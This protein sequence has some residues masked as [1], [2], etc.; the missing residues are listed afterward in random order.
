MFTPAC[1]NLIETQSPVFSIEIKRRLSSRLFPLTYNPFLKGVD[2]LPCEACFY[3][4]GGYWLCD[5]K[6]HLLCA[7]CFQKCPHCYKE[8]CP[9]CH[10]NSCPRCDPKKK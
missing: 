8:F 4:R 9:L 6:L 3:P 1:L 10:K 5:E 7:N 2:P